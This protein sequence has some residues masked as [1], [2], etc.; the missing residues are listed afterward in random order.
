MFLRFAHVANI[1][2]TRGVADQKL[3]ESNGRRLVELPWRVNYPRAFLTTTVPTA[4]RAMLNTRTFPCV[5]SPGC[6]FC[7]S[8][9]DCFVIQVETFDSLRQRTESCKVVGRGFGLGQAQMRVDEPLVQEAIRS[10]PRY[11][12]KWFND[13]ECFNTDS[14]VGLS[15]AMVIPCRAAASDWVILWQNSISHLVCIA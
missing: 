13:L 4:W 14:A 3:F 10:S 5:S 15:G 9:G 6:C 12:T 1:D 8:M 7:L 11:A 2:S